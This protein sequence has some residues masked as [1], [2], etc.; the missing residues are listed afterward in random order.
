M[1]FVWDTLLLSLC[2]KIYL[3][4]GLFGFDLNFLSNL[5]ICL[6][7]SFIALVLF[8]DFDFDHLVLMSEVEELVVEV[9]SCIRV[10]WP[11]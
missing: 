3:Y 2:A 10:L 4:L 7:Y 8:G 11:N 5:F 6:V 9:M 1:F